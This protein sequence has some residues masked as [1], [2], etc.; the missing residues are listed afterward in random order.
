MTNLA[1]QLEMNV[2]TWGRLRQ[3]GV[4]E[5]TALRLDFMYEAPTRGA[6]DKLVQLLRDETDYDVSEPLASGSPVPT[7]K[8]FVSGTTQ[9]TSVS[10][11]VLNQWVDWM[12]AAGQQSG[13]CVFDGWGAQVP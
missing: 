12:V 1:R 8:F 4:T 13:G 11:D 5:A 3:H 9:S 10:L 6:A 2:E 7:P